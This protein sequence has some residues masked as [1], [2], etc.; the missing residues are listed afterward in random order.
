MYRNR[1]HD[2]ATTAATACGCRGQAAPAAS[3]A[4]RRGH[5]GLHALPLGAAVLEP[6]L[7]LD[8]AEPQRMGDLRALGEAEVLLGVK[9]LFQLE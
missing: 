2:L 4:G 7:D 8:L 1:H 6:D 9:L 3:A 5:A